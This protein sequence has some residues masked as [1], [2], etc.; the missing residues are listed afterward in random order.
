MRV[1]IEGGRLVDPAQAIDQALDLHLQDGKVAGV[2][3]RPPSFE[4]EQTISAHGRI[5]APGLVDLCAR[6]REPG[7]EHKA[8]IASETRAAVKAGIT[9][10]CLPP[11]TTPVIDE[12]SVVE[13]VRRRNE[14]AGLC[15]VVVLGAL[16]Q[17]LEG[18]LLSEMAALLDAGCVG[19]SNA[20]TPVSS[21]LVM[22]RA[23]EY[24]ATYGL[25]VFVHAADPWLSAR[26]AVHEGVMATRLG[27]PGIPP[28]AETAIIGR[29]LALVEE[30]G[31]R[32]HFCRLSTARGVEM[33]AEAIRRGLPVSADAAAHQFHLTEHDLEEFNSMCHLVPPV[34][35]SRDVE[36]L[37]RAAAAS[38]I[39]TVCSDH[40]PHEA[41]AKLNPFGDTEPGITALETLLPLTLELT[42]SGLSLTQALEL[43]T[44]GPA[45]TLG[46]ECGILTTG[47][48]ADI[49]IFDPDADWVLETEALL[50]SGKNT[51]FAG[52][53]M[54]GRVT[55]TLVD[56]QLVYVAP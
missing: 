31:V 41:D 10:L 48:P 2:G 22:R 9:T 46:L 32:T 16:T 12:P 26:G 11:D 35:T 21:T 19:V 23:M 25:T 1:S 51:P 24:A 30:V 33:V 55:H 45:R 52:R 43:L 44:A 4:P 15:K 3:A 29:D 34:R 20:L 27:L 53:R 40:Q 28:S 39:S 17:G 8:T 14:A 38:V 56:G 5:V 42:T 37:T 6:L 47:A 13:L 36:A 7:Q 49:C 54:R 50:S 18:Q